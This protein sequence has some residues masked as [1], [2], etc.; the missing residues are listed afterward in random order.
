MNQHMGRGSACDFQ[1]ESKLA[2]VVD[3]C[4]RARS[5]VTG[6]TLTDLS[7]SFTQATLE[8]LGFKCDD[9]REIV[10]IL[11]EGMRRRKRP[12]RVFYERV[13]V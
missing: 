10:L 8:L 4:S 11:V 9:R 13:H 2:K 3:A 7:L 12:F 5:S 1:E 6:F